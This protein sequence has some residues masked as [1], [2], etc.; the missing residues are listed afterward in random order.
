MDANFLKERL[1]RIQ[2]LITEEYKVA[3]PIK[4]IPKGYMLII[5]RASKQESNENK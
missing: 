3:D 4:K 5:E 1:K 2:N